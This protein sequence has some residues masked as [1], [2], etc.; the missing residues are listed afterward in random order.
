LQVKYVPIRPGDV[1]ESQNSPG[2]LKKLFPNV[3]PKEFES[4]LSETIQWLKADGQS[5][6]NG[7]SSID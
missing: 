6:A 2:L 4:A 1:K 7:P 3:T 5:V